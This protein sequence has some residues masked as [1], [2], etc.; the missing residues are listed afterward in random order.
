MNRL[1]QIFKDKLCVIGVSAIIV[2]TLSGILLV[3]YLVR[4]YVPKIAQEK[5][6]K[7]AAI[8]EVRFNPYVFTF[9]ANDFR[10]DE[11]NGEPI[12]G[13]KRLFVDFELK[14]LFKWA[15]TFKQIAVE[16]PHLNTIIAQ[17]GTLNLAQIVPASD[18]TPSEE[19]DKSLPRL[20][21]EH[22]IIDQGRIDFT[23]KRQSE[24]ATVYLMPLNL[25]IEN[26]TSLPEQEGSKT[27]TATTGDGETFRW[28][29]NISLNPVA[30]NGTLTFKN[31][32]TATLWKFVR[33]AVNLESPAGK[34]TVTADYDLDLGDVA[35][36]LTLDNFS[37]SLTGVVLKLKDAQV[38]FL[39][40]PDT[41]ITGSEFDLIKQQGEIKK[42]TVSGG[43]ARLLVDES[44]VLNLERIV[45]DS[46]LPPP[47]A[48][49]PSA[50][51]DAGTKPWKISLSSFNLAGFSLDYLDGSRSPGLK[52]GIESIK[53][54]LK[55]QAETGGAQPK[56]LIN[57]IAVEFS[58]IAA[59][60]ADSPEP[61]VRIDNITL[62]GGT[63]DQV[64]NTFTVENIA[65]NGGKVDLKR[66]ADG[67][68]NLVLLA[69]PP[70]RGLVAKEIE[71]METEGHPIQFLAKT[72]TVSGLETAFSDLSVQP[73]GPIIHFEDISTVL[74]KVD[75]KS[76]M[77]FNLGL[78]IHEGGQVKA[79][80]TI[81]PALPS[82]ES[83]IQVL[84]FG[85]APFQPYIDQAVSLELKSGEVSTRGTLKYGMKEA[86]SQT[87]FNGAFKVE[88]LR[89]VEPQGT[90][91]FL[92]WKS[93]Q[94]DQLK[95][96]LEPDRLEIGEMKLAQ[97]V[98]K[99]IIYEDKTLNITRVIKTNIDS[100]TDTDT[101]TM[102]EPPASAEASDSASDSFPVL[103]RRLTLSDGKMEF[104]DL[105]LTPQFGTRIHELKGVVAGI[106]TE[107]D[108]R[109]QVKLDGRV[110]E[111]GTANID[112]EVN[113][114]NPKAFTNMSVVFHNVEMTRLT[115][116]SGRFA[117]RKIDSGKLSVDLKYDIQNSRLVGDNQ[118]VVERL[119][120]GERVKS[121]D[122]VNLPLD[123]AIALLED[124]NGVIDIGLP[125]RGDIDS[126][127][128]SY[129]ALIWKA[130]TN[131]IT[132]I[133]TSPFRALGALLPGGGEETLNIIT[134]K[135]GKPIIPPPEKEK[136]V[137]LANALQKRP[138]LKLMVQG[139][140]NP[141]TDLAE[142]RSASLRLSLAIHQ[143]QDLEVGEDPGPVDFSSSDTGKILEAMFVANF[144]SDELKAIKEELKAAEKKMKE[145][146]EDKREAKDPGQLAKKLFARLVD[147]EPVG[148]PELV[149]L[150]DTRSQGIMEELTGPGGFPVERIGIKPSAAMTNKDQPTALLNLEV[151]K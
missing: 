44:G 98:G 73:D 140:Y 128:F 104:A 27:I 19:K 108:A 96:H 58:K 74:N 114:S 105:S 88:N 102:S 133:A 121:P 21:F 55:A 51:K 57:D 77:T 136:L 123:L 150:A 62:G 149:K 83:E 97:L 117:G 60:L 91:T 101:A 42:V 113:T 94:T 23:D 131:L 13:F 22:L 92:G 46:G 15:W 78:K 66:Q 109:A 146:K 72:I 132:R 26:L 35:P 54:D 18:T 120:L 139:R 111:F 48:S 63:F 144:G 116:Y 45:K 28:T 141:E 8:G 76:P 71:E 75:G 107:Q 4:H 12:A 9:E 99:F 151:V 87:E 2:Y 25:D 33:D 84:D 80:G 134:F 59:G 40:L 47:A 65:V 32:R 70:R 95:L 64:P 61:E 6:E 122:A 38:P 130:F 3:P 118:I 147:V 31:I 138:K 41:R 30:T 126:P 24:P 124:T 145:L 7:S 56:V 110:D 135:P 1:V 129:G 103:V 90:E 142:L 5:L 148:T 50:T 119:S 125:V 14:S 115:P 81:D 85:L 127:E 53:V 36:K 16:Q 20:I 106:S 86:G 37:S 112:G 39:E 79:E 10:M 137:K 69:A 17:N 43:I 11:P 93:L 49:E 100:K 89:L 52:A 67:D 143:G 34:L 68:I 82:V 29:G